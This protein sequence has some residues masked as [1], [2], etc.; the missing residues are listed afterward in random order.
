[1]PETLPVVLSPEEVLQFLSCI[2]STKHRAILATC[3][4]AGLRISEAVCLKTFD[5]DLNEW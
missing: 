3:Y 5:I 1:M 2:T 4:T